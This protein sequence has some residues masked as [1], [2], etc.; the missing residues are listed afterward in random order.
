M[1]MNGL[2]SFLIVFLLFFFWIFDISDISKNFSQNGIAFETRETTQVRI[3]T[4]EQVKICG[5]GTV[6]YC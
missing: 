2:L 5:D 6:P 1:V 4:K 3:D